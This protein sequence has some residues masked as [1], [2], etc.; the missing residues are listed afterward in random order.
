MQPPRKRRPPAPPRRKY[1]S[2]TPLGQPGAGARRT[3]RRAPWSVGQCCPQART[4]TAAAP[5]PQKRDGRP[6]ARGA[7][8]RAR[9]PRHHP[10][11]ARRP[12]GAG[13][14]SFF[15]APRAS[16]PLLNTQ[17]GPARGAAG[18]P[19]HARRGERRGPGPRRARRA[20]AA[21]DGPAPRGHGSRAAGGAGGLRARGTRDGA[22]AG[23]DFART[24][25]GA[26]FARSGAGAG[27]RAG[28]RAGA[29]AGART[30]A[31]RRRRGTCPVPLAV[32][33]AVARAPG[34]TAPPRLDTR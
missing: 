26:D 12:A 13:A 10:R 16:H 4:T 15:E 33:V 24:A 11:A 21:G 14:E 1:H 19:R 20:G 7:P 8:V 6:R 34:R 31:G 25:H 22:R 17:A 3:R 29:G 30:G 5:L 18:H 28:A 27:A 9:R 32:A 23:A 2:N